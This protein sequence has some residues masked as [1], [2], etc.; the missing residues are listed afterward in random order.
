MNFHSTEF[1]DF[2]REYHFKR[3]KDGDHS[4]AKPV[5]EKPSAVSAREQLLARLNR[6]SPPMDL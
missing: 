2:A 4:V 1:S 5:A 6:T 3:R